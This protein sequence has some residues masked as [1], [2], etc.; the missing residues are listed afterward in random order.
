MLS[1]S[2]GYM[3]IQTNRNTKIIFVLHF[4]FKFSGALLAI[5]SGIFMLRTIWEMTYLT[6]TEGPQMIGFS[7]MHRFPDIFFAILLCYWGF[8]L[9]GFIILIISFLKREWNNFNKFILIFLLIQV[10]HFIVSYFYEF[11][12]LSS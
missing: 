1:C 11:W 10:F 5:G 9:Y 8:F 7:I 4:I 3:I 6:F 2:G 12:S